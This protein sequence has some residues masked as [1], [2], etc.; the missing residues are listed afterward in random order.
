MADDEVNIRRG[1]ATLPWPQWGLELVGV[2]SDGVQAWDLIQAHRPA[3]VLTDIRMPGLSGL[4][5]ARLIRDFDPDTVVLLLSGHQD[6]HY[7]QEAIRHGVFGYLL[8]PTHPSEIEE[9]LRRA[10]QECERR[11]RIGEQLLGQSLGALARGS[12][13]PPLDG[14]ASGALAALLEDYQI[15][16]VR[17]SGAV[18]PEEDA[19]DEGLTSTA[20]PT[21]VAVPVAGESALCYL[22]HPSLDR[23]AALALGR[24]LQARWP[25]APGPVSVGISTPSRH[26]G[27]LPR[28]VSEAL[29]A[30]SDGFFRG[31][32]E[33]ILAADR[34]VEA[35]EGELAAN[36]PA[37]AQRILEDRD[38]ARL[39]LGRA[40]QD[41]ARA[42]GHD[43]RVFRQLAA[44]LVQQIVLRLP[45]PPSL[46]LLKSRLEGAPTF[47]SLVGEAWSL[48]EPGLADLPGRPEGQDYPTLIQKALRY[49]Q[50]NLGR[51]LSLDS[52]AEHV[53]LNPSY[54][55]RLFK[56]EAHETFQSCLTRLRLERANELLR[57]T[58]LKAYQVAPL[59]GFSDA[60]YFSAV[61]RKHYG[62]SPAD[63]RQTVRASRRSPFGGTPE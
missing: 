45:S 16:A 6:F 33:V 3:L 15:W 17:A 32:G 54:F 41:L 39:G 24:Q 46:A 59:I 38:Q 22:A 4:E 63:Y 11:R 5:L 47:E 25:A 9:L 21:M 18:L 1:L 56:Q 12:R 44:E 8:K 52:T 29:G 14:P 50:D 19:P 53:C 36:L 27:D 62:R 7:A 26:A 34:S 37:L 10:L 48:L 30:L 60:K 40:M 35:P 28:L 42:V 55:S 58:D 2:A 31:T 20:G 57:T 43:E 23:E 61:Y 51:D 13:H 49:M